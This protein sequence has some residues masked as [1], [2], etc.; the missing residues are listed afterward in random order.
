MYKCTWV[1]LIAERKGEEQK[2]PADKHPM[3]P[4]E[5]CISLYKYS[6]IL[7][8]LSMPLWGGLDLLTIHPSS[9]AEV[10]WGKEVGNSRVI[11][12][13]MAPKMWAF[14]QGNIVTGSYVSIELIPK[15]MLQGFRES[16]LIYDPGNA[17]HIMWVAVCY[18]N[19]KLYK[20][21]DQKE[22]YTRGFCKCNRRKYLRS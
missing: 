11:D 10:A 5:L 16:G 8:V 18:M 22:S 19:C 4:W 13:D 6:I 2:N 21:Q 7:W 15:K 20:E 1:S 9:I 17:I 3:Y 14:I 12:I